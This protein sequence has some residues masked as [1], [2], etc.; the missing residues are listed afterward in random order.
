MRGGEPMRD[1]RS[2]R[3]EARPPGA[4]PGPPGAEPEPRRD[5][6]S[7]SPTAEPAGAPPLDFRGDWAALAAD[8]VAR[9]GRPGLVGQFMQQSEL[10]GHDADG[11]TLRVPVKPLAE[12]ALLAKVREVLAAVFG[13]PV[14][15]AVEVGQVRGT[16]VAQ[17]RS[18]EQAE[19]LA[20][21]QA[22]IEGDAF[23]QTLLTGFEGTIVPDSI[24]PVGSTGESR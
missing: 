20:Q 1:A 22:H 10:L 9:L 17:V 13:R 8:V 24:Q 2:P 16:T 3:A 4:E 23:V 7:P 15:L 11:F 18:R 12:P 21:A 14:R 6:P 5:P 19:A